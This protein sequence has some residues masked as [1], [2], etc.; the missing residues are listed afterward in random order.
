M[1]NVTGFNKDGIRVCLKDKEESGSLLAYLDLVL[2]ECGFLRQPSSTECRYIHELD[3]DLEVFVETFTTE[4]T[5][6]FYIRLG[7]LKVSLM[8]DSRYPNRGQALI[9]LIQSLYKN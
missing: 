6:I 3:S 4:K 2:L 1:S 8:V 7:S 9:S 5:Y